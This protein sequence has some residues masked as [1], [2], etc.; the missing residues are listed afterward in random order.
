MFFT[1]THTSKEQNIVAKLLNI[2]A[3]FKNTINI[4]VC[5]NSA[6]NTY[7]LKLLIVHS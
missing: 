4:P 1:S 7:N 5:V 3:D 2:Y 6:K